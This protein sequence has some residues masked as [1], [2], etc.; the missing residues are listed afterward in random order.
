MGVKGSC[1]LLMFDEE[2]IS[3]SRSASKLWGVLGLTG[4]ELDSCSVRG[5]KMLKRLLINI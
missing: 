2:K 4:E 3:G 5:E 1:Q